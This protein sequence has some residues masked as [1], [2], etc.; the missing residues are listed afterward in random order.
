MFYNG[1]ETM[2]DHLYVFHQFSAKKTYSVY[3][4]DLDFHHHPA[5][6]IVTK[7]KFLILGV[8]KIHVQNLTMYKCKELSSKNFHNAHY[9]CQWKKYYILFKSP[10]R[11]TFKLWL[12]NNDK[13]DCTKKPFKSFNTADMY[14][15]RKATTKDKPFCHP[16]A[17]T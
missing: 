15:K 14:I 11:I 6:S 9:V 13:L 3:T 4:A 16:S 7:H 5:H 10:M 1:T 8:K 17:Q 2:I 12:L